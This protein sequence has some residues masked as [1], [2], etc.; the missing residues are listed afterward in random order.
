MRACI[1]S[2]TW[3]FISTALQQQLKENYLS[4]G[5]CCKAYLASYLRKLLDSESCFHV[6][7]KI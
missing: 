6:D 3:F 1:P 4:T 7:T 2:D 5:V